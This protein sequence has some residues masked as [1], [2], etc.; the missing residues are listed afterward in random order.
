MFSVRDCRV[1]DGATRILL[2]CMISVPNHPKSD[3]IRIVSWCVMGHP[4]VGVHPYCVGPI[5]S[6]GQFGWRA[7][8]GDRGAAFSC[9]GWGELSLCGCLDVLLAG[10][11][12]LM[13]LGSGRVGWGACCVLVITSA[14]GA[15]EY[16]WLPFA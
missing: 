7:R 8:S 2:T 5:A 9:S 12:G 4:W 14:G 11:L 1:L 3:T 6:A 16:P 15:C 13:V 10:A